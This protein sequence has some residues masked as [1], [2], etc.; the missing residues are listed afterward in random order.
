MFRLFGL[1]LVGL[2]LAGCQTTSRS[3]KERAELVKS[4]SDEVI[5]QFAKYGQAFSIYFNEAKRRGLSCG[6]GEKSTAQMASSSTAAAYIS[7]LSDA[8]VC[9][10]A[11]GYYT[12]TWIPYSNYTKEAK[13]RG[14]SC[15][16]GETSTTQT[17]SST[18]T[19]P[20][21]ITTSAELTASQK[22]AERLRQELAALK[23]QQ[24]QQQQ[25]ISNDTQIPFIRK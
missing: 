16:I 5:C 21:N 10:I 7:K 15:G 2:V 9:S 18:T 4:E 13:R 25:T 17:A 3:Y 1:L 19:T 14:L 8:S 11:V 24:E 6:V 12:K 22:E 23:A 20:S